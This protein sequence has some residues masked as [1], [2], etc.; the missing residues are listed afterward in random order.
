M[1]YLYILDM[2]ECRMIQCQNNATCQNLDGSYR[3][4][5]REGF[6]G[7]YCEKGNYIVTFLLNSRL[8]LLYYCLWTEKIHF[9]MWLLQ[10]LMNAWLSLRAYTAVNASTWWV[11]TGVSVRRDG[12]AKT[13][14][15]VG[16]LDGLS[17]L[18]LNKIF[19]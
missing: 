13:A 5:C 7:K 18:L 14:T 2:D 17:E 3:C 11:D 19:R 12:S 1:V 16:V 10:I 9:E 15:G 8:W 6:E 4:V